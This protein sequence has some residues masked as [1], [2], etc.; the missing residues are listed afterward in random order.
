MYRYRVAVVRTMNLSSVE[1]HFIWATN[2]YAID[3][4]FNRLGFMVV[5]NE[6]VYD[7]RTT[8]TE[9]A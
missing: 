2:K 4:F 9:G 6:R 5:S 8:R 1:K 7:Q 3:R